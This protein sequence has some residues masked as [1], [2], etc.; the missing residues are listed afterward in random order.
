MEAI[1]SRTTIQ[2]IAS[3]HGMDL[4][5]AAHLPVRPI[6]VSQWKKQLFES[7]SELFTRGKKTEAKAEIQAKD[8][9]LFQQIGKLQIG[10]ERLK[11]ISATMLPA[12]FSS[13]S[14][15]TILY[16]ASAA[17][18]SFWFCLDPPITTGPLQ[19]WNRHWASWP[20]SMRFIWRIPVA[21]AAEWWT[22]WLENAFRSA[23]IEYET[24]CGGWVYG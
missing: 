2:E 19:S 8:T 15:Q 7:A 22:T 3:D 17:R 5:Y 16:S 18:A 14:I 12:N 20:G 10:L 6:Q 23:E 13:L 21:V 4:L 1:S 24:S 9:E 11:K